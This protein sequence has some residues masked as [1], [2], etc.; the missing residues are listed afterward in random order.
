MLNLTITVTVIKK[1]K[2]HFSQQTKTILETFI[3]EYH[4]V[5]YIQLA[6]ICQQTINPVFNDNKDENGYILKLN[7]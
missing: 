1:Y 7:K 2:A 4:Q 5:H 3:G 6:A